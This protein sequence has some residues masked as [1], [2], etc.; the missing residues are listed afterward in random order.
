[1]NDFI[2]LR[3]IRTLSVDDNDDHYLVNVEGIVFPTICPHCGCEKLYK[4]GA[5]EQ[6]YMDTPMHG[7]RVVLKLDRKRYKCTNQLCKKTI[8]EPLDDMDS[9]RLATQ[10]LVKYVEKHCFKKHSQ[11][12]QEKLV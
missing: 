8:F 9:K 6:I 4:H 1:M 11:T 12:S 10:R 5:V 7:K 3:Y 2:N